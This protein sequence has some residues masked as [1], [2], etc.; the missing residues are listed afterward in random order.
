MIL[1][2]VILLLIV[3][4]LC[5]SVTFNTI[6]KCPKYPLKIKYVRCSRYPGKDYQIRVGIDAVNVKLDR[7]VPCGIYKITSAYGYGVL[8]VSNSDPRQ[9]YLGLDNL[10]SVKGVNLFD[11]WDLQ[12]MESDDNKLIQ[13]YNR[14]CCD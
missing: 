12:R 1:Q 2:L 8:F 7:D 6:Y 13:T 4:L 5:N 3:I 10:D 9:G 14:G 11:L